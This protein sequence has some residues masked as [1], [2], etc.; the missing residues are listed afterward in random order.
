M[1]GHNFIR[2][3]VFDENADRLNELTRFVMTQRKT[4][5][6]ETTI[7]ELEAERTRLRAAAPRDQAVIDVAETRIAEVREE[8]RQFEIATRAEIDSNLEKWR[9]LGAKKEEDVITSYF[10]LN[11]PEHS[12]EDWIAKLRADSVK[13]LVNVHFKEVKD[14]L[15]KNTNAASYT[16]DEH[17]AGLAT[18]DV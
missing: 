11:I 17:E 14:C 6:Y 3:E 9:A 18:K 8:K 5:E 16:E 12:L 15:Y 4:A 13:P 1:A 2:N 7:T 10:T